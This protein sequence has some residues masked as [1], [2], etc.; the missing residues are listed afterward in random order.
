MLLPIKM[1]GSVWGVSAHACYVE[2]YEKSFQYNTSWLSNFMLATAALQKIQG[3]I[4][5]VLWEGILDRVVR[6]LMEELGEVSSRE[7]FLNAL[8]GVNDKLAGEQLL[9][10]YALPQ[11]WIED[12]EDDAHGHDEGHWFVGQRVGV[13]A[14][15]VERFVRMCWTI[16]ENDFFSARQPW[17]KR[18]TRSFIT[19]VD[20]GLKRALEQLKLRR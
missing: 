11:F 6:L 14:K 9:T 8:A 19:V 5:R 18:G 17:S 7:G 10:P 13:D 16:K 12:A 15:G 3:R 2:D 4:D 20:L 1:R